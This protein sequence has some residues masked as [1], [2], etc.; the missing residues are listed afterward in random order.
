M[1]PHTSEWTSSP[2]QFALVLPF[3]R[4]GDETFQAHRWC[5]VLLGLSVQ[6]LDLILLLDLELP[7]S[8]LI[9]DS[10]AQVSGARLLTMLED[11]H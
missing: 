4:G 7:S 10:C 1:G 9:G 2:L 3:L 5:R 8:E 6:P 11:L